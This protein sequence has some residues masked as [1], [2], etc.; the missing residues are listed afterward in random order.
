M[1]SANCAGSSSLK[2]RWLPAAPALHP[3]RAARHVRVRGE[4]VGQEQAAQRVGDELAQRV[5]LEDR[6]DAAAADALGHEAQAGEQRRRGGEQHG[7]G[8][9]GTDDGDRVVAGARKEGAENVGAGEQLLDVGGPL[10]QA[11]GPLLGRARL[12][13]H[14]GEQREVAVGESFE[15]QQVGQ[16][17]TLVPG[18]AGLS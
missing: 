2:R 15:Q 5:D 8:E 7:E 1:S 18:G 14:F 9:E 4:Q 17:V 12:A 16:H 10:A 11:S 6:H 3:E 13:R